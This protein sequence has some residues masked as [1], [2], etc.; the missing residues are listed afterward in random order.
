MKCFEPV[1]ASLIYSWLIENTLTH[2]ALTGLTGSL[3]STCEHRCLFV[4]SNHILMS[5]P[6]LWSLSP[7]MTVTL[8]SPFHLYQCPPSCG[9]QSP[10]CSPPTLIVWLR[11]QHALLMPAFTP[12]PSPELQ[13]RMLQGSCHHSHGQISLSTHPCSSPPEVSSLRTQRH[14]QSS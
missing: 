8:F 1:A 10:S 11:V 4:F 12:D 13:K 2:P 7:H 3:S 14:P 6:V 9:L 5:S